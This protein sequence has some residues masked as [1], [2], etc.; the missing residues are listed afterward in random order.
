MKRRI[1]IVEDEHALAA[2]LDTVCQR[3]GAVTELAPSGG[4]ALEV[5]ND[6]GPFDLVILDI[7]LP[8]MSGLDVLRTAFPDE[9]P[10][11]VPVL[12]ITA[13]GNLENAIAARKLG[14]AEYLLKPLDL[15][16]FQEALLRLLKPKTSAAETGAKPSS[17]VE[18][19]TTLIGAAPAMQQVFREVA[20]ACTSQSPV[21][22]SGA[23]GTGKSLTARVIHRNS[24]VPPEN[25][26]IVD[27]DAAD[28]LPSTDGGTT[29]VLE[30][31]D[32]LKPPAQAQ[33]LRLI[34]D[35]EARV[36]LVATTHSSLHDQVASGEFREDLY[37]RLHVLSIHLPDLRERTEDI[38]ALAAYFLGRAESDRALT[39]SEEAA[40]ELVSHGW[41]GNVLELR[42]AIDYAVSICG[43]AQILPQH[44]PAAVTLR[45]AETSRGRSELERAIGSWLDEKLAHDGVTYADLLGQVES[46]MLKDLLTRFDGKPTRLASALG[47]NRT[48]LRK[49]CSQ[50]LE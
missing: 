24:D 22:I 13:H 10:I 39:I 14:I 32:A 6:S 48:T 9:T 36:R 21:V 35:P 40:A 49:K 12:V 44:L 47:M 20:H 15:P 7:G 4:K 37:Y 18:Q 19:D 31:I 8:D 2:A 42:N 33:L 11:P 27:C 30:N 5:L 43:G 34:E 50:C 26:Q 46:T 45:G 41:P 1:L 29:L 3:T 25:L 17:S 28:E 16:R 23:T 38:P